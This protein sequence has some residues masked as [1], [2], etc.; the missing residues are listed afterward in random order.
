MHIIQANAG[1]LHHREAPGLEQLRLGL[2][3]SWIGLANYEVSI[4]GQWREIDLILFMDH[5]VL[6][7]DLKDWTGKVT[8]SAGHWFCGGHDRKTS[9]VR[10]L[11]GLARPVATKLRALLPKAGQFWVDTAVVHTGRMDV[12]AL[13]LDERS[14]VWRIDTFVGI[15]DEA[16]FKK[17]FPNIYRRTHPLCSTQRSEIEAIV[18]G[19]GTFRP[20]RYRFNSYEPDGQPIAKHAEEFYNEYE[21]INPEIRS[22]ALL[23]IWNLD[24]LPPELST[25]DARRDTILREP[26]ILQLLQDRSRVFEGGRHLLAFQSGE[27]LEDLGRVYRELYTLPPAALRVGP[28]LAR[29][30]DGLDDDLRIR[31]CVALLDVVAELH[32]LQVAHCDLKPHAVW[33]SQDGDVRVSAFVCASAPEEKTIPASA[34]ALLPMVD[35]QLPEHVY[36][37]GD[38]THFVGDVYRLG[39]ICHTILYGVEPARNSEGLREWRH[40]SRVLRSGVVDSWFERVLNLDWR[41]RPANA[42][43]ARDS[44]KS[45]LGHG[46]GSES[47][48]EISRYLRPDSNVW[49]AYPP[50]QGGLA[51]SSGVALYRSLHQG[52]ACHVK[53]WEAVSSH[54]ARPE[55]APLLPELMKLEGLAASRP[56]VVAQV[57]DYGISP[58]GAYLIT[59][60]VDGASLS[61]TPIKEWALEKRIALARTVLQAL[62]RLH[63]L[64]I[65]HGDVNPS[66]IMLRA[67]V[68]ATAVCLIDYATLDNPGR[69]EPHTPAYSPP[70]WPTASRVYR[71]AFGTS[72]VIAELA[73][74]NVTRVADDVSVTGSDQWSARLAERINAVL[75]W[76]SPEAL[77]AFELVEDALELPAP[78]VQARLVR[79]GAPNV[80]ATLPMRPDGEDY[81]V[82]PSAAGAQ[83]PYLDLVGADQ[84]LRLFLTDSG[85]VAHLTVRDTPLALLRHARNT[86]AQKACTLL[87]SLRVVIERAPALMLSELVP[88]L[89]VSPTAAGAPPKAVQQSAETTS[90]EERISVPHLWRIVTDALAEQRNT[91]VVR[92]PSA[93]DDELTYVKVSGLIPQSLS[94]DIVIVNR[95]TSLGEEQQYGILESFNSA[96]VM[97]IK[98]ADRSLELAAGETLVLR[99]KRDESSRYRRRIASERILQRRGVISDLIDRLDP[100]R[101]PLP[102]PIPG[103][104]PDLKKYSLNGGQEAIFRE[105]LQKG[106][107]YFLQGPPGTGKTK[108]I[109]ALVHY[110]VKDRNARKILVAS[111][112][113]EAVN[114]AAQ[115]IGRVFRA[116]GD[117]LDL[118]RFGNE[119]NLSP[120][121]RSVH[122][123]ALR[124]EYARRLQREWDDRHAAVADNLAIPPAVSELAIRFEQDVLRPLRLAKG[125]GEVARPSPEIQERQQGLLGMAF[126]AMNGLGLR[127]PPS[128]AA[129]STSNGLVAAAEAIC[130]HTGH[131]DL[132][133]VVRFFKVT[134][135]F[136]ELLERLSN[137][138]SRAFAEFLARVRTVVCGT[139]VGLGDPALQFAE[140]HFDWVIVDEAG[141]C[142]PGELA[143]AI[144]SARRVLLVG[145]HMQLRPFVD[146]GLKTY[147]TD[148]HGSLDLE[149]VLG[150]DFERAF[151]ANLS[152]GTASQ[153][154]AQYR[155]TAPIG[156]MVSDLVYDSKLETGR[157]PAAHWATQAPVIGTADATWI[158]TGD[159]GAQAYES[160]RSPGSTSYV[161]LLEARV[162]ANLTARLLADAPTASSLR[163]LYDEEIVPIGVIAAYADQVDEIDEQID[164]LVTHPEL[165]RLVRVGTIDSYQGKQNPIVIVSLVRANEK[166][167]AG[168]VKSLERINVAL[169]R[170]QE[171]LVVV[172]S[173]TMW[174]HTS[175]CETLV[176]RTCAYF[177]E[178]QCV[179]GYQVLPSDTVLENLR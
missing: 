59:E 165:R 179:A 158:D 99:G 118:V 15:K 145:D 48:Q 34:R 66:N 39:I 52:A 27:S 125:W 157:G 77:V 134:R 168:H 163:S 89:P 26:K 175:L 153:L 140:K 120:D 139:C 112:T 70:N 2:P 32:R 56:E 45:A 96:N 141:R 73:G 35:V 11:E 102:A 49:I 131:G 108:F 92:N 74:L 155:M 31:L 162:I 166:S 138:D 9:A 30:R 19:S 10:K 149:Y 23:R 113:H 144:Q 129:L 90:S 98:G 117:R 160:K 150:S 127:T 122:L 123:T 53:V 82:L 38:G 146:E 93:V 46:S 176:G 121:L 85:T 69:A 1:G 36:D 40:P 94:D 76:R 110:L 164:E 44:F 104:V 111:Q 4:D 128:L 86:A 124:E 21:A 33:L 178:R 169:S 91:V 159:A 37:S 62:L 57:L 114:N 50:D 16:T 22:K 154:T 109:G 8:E 12:S 13:P 28:F 161:N 43:E 14:K 151:Q 29:T 97:A 80:A 103:E 152:Q 60:F 58:T 95:V 71:D 147:L 24:R 115:E 54:R 174:R 136:T 41:A 25:S 116:N 143:V 173:G 87:T 64:G 81:Y 65:A 101:V 167:N 133:S 20:E 3:R 42:L 132:D 148:R 67:G 6:L 75:R 88:L 107:V 130:E 137:D 61:N 7:V 172:G 105:V 18:R 47:L 72:L 51:R 78:D 171:R 177:W 63:E 119:K 5:G 106:P 100:D 17:F 55:L 126:S 156:S 84:S 170:A 68:A 83:R 142:H 135:V 79:V